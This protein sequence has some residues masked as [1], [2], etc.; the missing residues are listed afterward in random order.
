M[1]VRAQLRSPALALQALG[2]LR[3]LQSRGAR[4][5]RAFQREPA[6]S[7]QEAAEEYLLWARQRGSRH[8]RTKVPALT[9]RA[10]R[11]R[12]WNRH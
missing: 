12:R 9:E 8:I 5:G 11:Q 3:R 6:G 1:G 4:V 10:P 7:C 2:S